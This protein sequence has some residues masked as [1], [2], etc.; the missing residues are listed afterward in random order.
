MGVAWGLPCLPR[1]PTTCPEHAIPHHVCAPLLP[2]PI[3]AHTAHCPSLPLPFCSLL[4][5]PPTSNPLMYTAAVGLCMVGG[6]G[7]LMG[8]ARLEQ[9][10]R[11]TDALPMDVFYARA[12]V[13]L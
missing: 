5:A 13:S 11:D 4:R 10:R 6:F 3:P 7:G 1:V 8:A 12:M 9:Y 2:P